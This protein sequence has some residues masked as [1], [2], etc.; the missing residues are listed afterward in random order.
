MRILSDENQELEEKIISI[1]EFGNSLSTD[2]H[3]NPALHE[4]EKAW[5]LM[6]E[7]K[8][9][10]EMIGSWLTGSF[11]TAYFNLSDFKNAKHWAELQLKAENSEIDTAP[12]IDLGMVLFELGENEE[13]YNYLSKAYEYGKA[14]AFKERP[15]KYLDFYLTEKKKR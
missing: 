11:Y 9:E 4:Y 15:K 10:W 8:L 5:A 1:I 13:A 2:G 3:H 12:L 14:R 7:P 6:P